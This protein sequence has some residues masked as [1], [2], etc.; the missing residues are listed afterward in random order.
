M[1]VVFTI[2]LQNTHCLIINKHTTTTFPAGAR[3]IDIF[4]HV[5]CR[6]KHWTV[7]QMEGHAFQFTNNNEMKNT[8]IG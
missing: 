3:Y 7:V 5:Y 1:Y 6:T 4:W 8:N 2:E